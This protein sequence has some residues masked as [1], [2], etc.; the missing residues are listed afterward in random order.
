MEKEKY[1]WYNVT[2]H[3]W[4]YN[5]KGVDEKN[6]QFIIWKLERLVNYG[7]GNEKLPENLLK[8]YFKKIKMPGNTKAFLELLLWKKPY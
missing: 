1:W 5:L 4:D 2:M 6:E 8:K 7:L 3:N